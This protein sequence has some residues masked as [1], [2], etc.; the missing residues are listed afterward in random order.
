MKKALIAAS[1]VGAAAAGVI[2]Y[3]ARRNRLEYAIDGAANEL[4]DAAADAEEGVHKAGYL[5]GRFA[6]KAKRKMN[7]ATNGVM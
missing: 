1:I 4:D 3:L 2:L 5:A 7:H 6:R